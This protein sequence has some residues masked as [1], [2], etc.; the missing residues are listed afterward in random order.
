MEFAENLFTI[1]FDGSKLFEVE[2]DAF[3]NAGAVGIRT[4]AVGATLF[5]DFRYRAK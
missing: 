4:K 1:F 3:A 5:D 2:R